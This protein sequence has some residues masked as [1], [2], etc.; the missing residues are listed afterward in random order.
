MEIKLIA[1]DMDGTL[2]NSNVEITQFTKDTIK[3]AQDS[4]IHVAICTG[5]FP[6][7]VHIILDDMDIHCD[8]ISLNGAVVDADGK[9]IF[10]AFLPEEDTKNVYNILEEHDAKYILFKDHQIYTR[11][12]DTI[13]HAEKFYGDRMHDEYGVDFLR[14]E[15]AVK[16]AIDGGISKFFVF[17]DDTDSL[18]IVYDAVKTLP[19]IDVTRSGRKNFEVMPMGI[20]KATGL[21]KLAEYYN[22][23]IENTMAVGDHENDLSMI[24]V[25]GLSVAMANA[26]DLVKNAADVITQSNDDDGAAKAI[27]KYALKC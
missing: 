8:V 23:P 21:K 3:K 7:N 11:K 14:G 1:L 17:D 19:Q 6:E 5:R 18:D 10:S 13:Y 24:E 26:I 20:S 9:R 4:G 2:L 22:I 16:N 27:I 15:E 12:P 25:A